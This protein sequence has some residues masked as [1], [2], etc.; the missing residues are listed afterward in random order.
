M[1]FIFWDKL[2][3]TFQEELSEQEYEPIKYGL[4]K[5]LEK[6]DPI[7]LIFHEWKSIH[8]DLRKENLS[9]KQRLSYLFKAPGWSHDKSKLTSD[10]MRKLELQEKQ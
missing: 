6:K 8:R 7:T 1:C 10:E 2:F 9:W 5:P 3:G 4:T